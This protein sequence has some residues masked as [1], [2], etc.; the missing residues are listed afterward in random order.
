M[1]ADPYLC[2]ADFNDYSSRRKDMEK[3]Y[4]DKEAWAKKSLINIA[5]SGFFS[6]DRAIKEYADK[7]W[8]LK[9]VK[10]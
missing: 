4:Q 7:I 2:L 9:Q 6:A 10:K 8:H 3:V 5:N 1:I